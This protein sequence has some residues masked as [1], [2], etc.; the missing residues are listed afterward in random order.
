MYNKVDISIQ[1]RNT[2]MKKHDP[3]SPLFPHFIY[4]GDYNPDQW[5]DTPGIIDEDM[6]LM[7]LSHCNT[8]TLGIFSWVRLEPEDG[9]YDFS[10]LDNMIAKIAENGG[11]VILSTPSGSKPAWMSEKYPEILRTTEKQ[12]KRLHGGRHDHCLTSPVYRRKV[13]EMNERL[14]ERYGGNDAVIAWHISNEYGGECH[15]E[16]CQG[17]FREWLKKKYGGSLDEL[18]KAYWA[19]FWSHTFTSWS[20]LHSPSSIGENRIHGLSIDW[21]RFVSDQTIDFMK[22]EIKALRKYSDKP[23]TTNFMR[24]YSGI[25][26][27]KMAKE[28]DVVSW[29]SYPHWHQ[30]DEGDEYAGVAFD[31]DIFRSYK[32]KPFLLMESTPSLPNWHDINKLK[33]P[34]VN[35][36]G[37]LQAVAHGADSVQYF[38][39]RKSR[40]CSEKFHGAIV[41]HC[42]HENTRVFREVAELGKTLE[43]LDEVLGSVTE[44]ET[45]F[46]YELDNRLLIDTAQGFN[47]K[48]KKYRETCVRHYRPFWNRGINV[49]VRGYEEDFSKYKLIIAPMMYMVTDALIEKIERFVR[50]GGIFVTT[51]MAGMVDENDLCRLG[52]FPGGKLKEVFGIWNE[53]IDS[54]YPQDTNLVRIGEKEY[55]A[56]DYCEI[57][58]AEGAQVLGTYEKDFYAGCPALCCNSYGKGKAY[59]IAFRDK[60]EMLDDLYDGIIRE[61]GIKRS[62]D[63]T[64]GEGVVSHSRTDGETDFVFVGNYRASGSYFETNKEYTDMESGEKVLGRREMKPYES[65]ILKLKR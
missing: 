2:G 38:Q 31:H 59:Y 19:S 30:N 34:G 40:G 4:G 44:S 63:G 55:T 49:D 18:N 36:L 51:Y 35:R 12:Q 22:N 6:R 48:D 58:H 65:V 16:L 32:S 27:R 33:R 47:L 15:C 21:A 62:L 42:G 39:F 7:K 50:E 24:F 60:G 8:M 10:Y 11:K 37:A 41:D 53:E 1:R 25:D 64:L 9:K 23:V 46:L 26:Y 52:G 5:L 57:I 56:V 14:A 54:L 20:Q 43:G 45:A 61:A 13:R 17:A 3:I 28:L 29:D